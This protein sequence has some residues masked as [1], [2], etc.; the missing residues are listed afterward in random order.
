MALRNQG[1]IRQGEYEGKTIDEATQYAKDGGYTVRVTE[2][3]GQSKMLDMDANP[4]RINFRVRNGFVI[5]AY[6]G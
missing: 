3:N 5:D 6:G 1:M 4:N 2:E